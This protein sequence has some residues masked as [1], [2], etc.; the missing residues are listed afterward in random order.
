M[1]FIVDQGALELLAEFLAVLCSDKRIEGGQ[2]LAGP[3]P[4]LSV[5]SAW[6]HGAHLQYQVQTKLNLKLFSFL[7]AS[8]LDGRHPAH[9]AHYQRLAKRL[10]DC[11][12]AADGT[13]AQT[14]DWLEELLRGFQGAGLTRA[15]CAQT[16]FPISTAL[17]TRETIWGVS[18]ARREKVTDW[19]QLLDNHALFFS[20]TRRDFLARGGE[21]LYLQ[22]CNALR[23]DTTMLGAFVDRLRSV[24]QA[25][26]SAAEADPSQLWECLNAGFEALGRPQSPA[27]DRLIDLIENLD[28][29]TH[30]ALNQADGRDQGWLSCEW[31]PEEGW[32]EGYLFAVELA[33]VLQA[34]LDPV[35][36]IE[37][38]TTGCCLQ[39]LRSLSA[40]S[41][42]YAGL[43][44]TGAPLGYCWLFAPAEGASR[45]LRLASQRNLQVVLGRIQ[46][47]LRAPAL[48]ANAHGDTK[49][50]ETLYREAD[51]KYGHKLFLAL[52]KR[53][54]LIIPKRGAGARFAMTEDVLRYLVLALLRPG[55][56][57]TYDSFLN[58]L[59]LHYGI[60]I[61]GD[62][63][64]EAARWSD[65]PPTASIQPGRGSWP[66]D[67]LR[68][69]G[70]LVQLSD[71]CAVVRNTYAPDER[72]NEGGGR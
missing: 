7:S 31:C 54:G 42:R 4:D 24:E 27:F 30:R 61:E 60:A 26:I 20:T 3:L 1:R 8:R 72:S 22:L 37:V 32:P 64:S 36:R 34:T 66:A 11:V 50:V 45:P 19:D 59:Y 51:S 56:R 44:L 16:F 69:G 2:T 65:L 58:R 5:L 10:Q 57:C 47:A 41:A 29:E 67:A 70:F 14:V 46:K 55:E 9:I 25:S 39:V 43:P 23:T 68:A 33:R 62:L 52:G 17:L 38:L 53:L 6:P 40:Q 21:L 18:A 48:E 28:P 12:D 13:P 15:W 63:L 49:P 35:E 71:A